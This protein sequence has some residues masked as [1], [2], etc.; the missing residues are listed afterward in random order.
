MERTRDRMEGTRNHMERTR[1]RMEGTRNHMERTRDRM[2][3]TRNHM[4]RTRERMEGTRNNMERTRDHLEAMSDRIRSELVKDR[5]I[6]SFESKFRFELKNKEILLN[7]KRLSDKLFKK[8][9]QLLS[10]FPI[11]DTGPNFVIQSE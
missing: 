11:M 10:E 3:G 2:E 6:T 5:L 7:G 8:Y 4:E 9:Q 1:D